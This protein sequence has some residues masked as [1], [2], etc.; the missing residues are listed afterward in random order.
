MFRHYLCNTSDSIIIDLI[1][2]FL[3]FFRWNYLLLLSYNWAYL[4]SCFEC[5]QFHNSL[6]GDAK[7]FGRK[8][9][10]FCY[11]CIPGVMN[12]H[13]KVVQQWNKILAIFC[14]VAIFVDP[15]FFFLL[16]I[17]K[18][19]FYSFYLIVKFCKLYVVYTR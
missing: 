12:P 8:L 15:L 18:V 14:L 4:C 19:W 7:G 13:T 6:Y 2:I 3:I 1:V 10:S 9:V 16:Y 11:S 5:W 17:K